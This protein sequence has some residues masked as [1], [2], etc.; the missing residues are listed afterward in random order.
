MFL[1]ACNF[2]GSSGSDSDTSEKSYIILPKSEDEVVSSEKA[3]ASEF[4][5]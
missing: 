4:N 3:A 2:S 1:T 5:R